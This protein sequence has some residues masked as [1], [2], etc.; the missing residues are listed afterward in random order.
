MARKKIQVKKEFARKGRR[1]GGK[2]ER[3][4]KERR[5]ERKKERKISAG[6]VKGHICI[7]L[8]PVMYPYF[9]S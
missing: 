6:F 8:L 9:K 2:R 1:K 7:F 4:E 5:Q 3:S